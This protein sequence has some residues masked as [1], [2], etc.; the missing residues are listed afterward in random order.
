MV[1]DGRKHMSEGCRLS[2]AV[3]QYAGKDTEKVE[4]ILIENITKYIRDWQKKPVV[5]EQCLY[6]SLIAA[7]KI[8]MMNDLSRLPSIF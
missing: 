8:G 4:Q 5:S 7:A 2:Y 6:H 3:N 1:S